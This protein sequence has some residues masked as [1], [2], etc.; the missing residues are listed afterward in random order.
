MKSCA[1][2]AKGEKK[3]NK[4]ILKGAA[5]LSI[6]AAASLAGAYALKK[7]DMAGKRKALD[8]GTSA[9]LIYVLFPPI[10]EGPKDKVKNVKRFF[11]YSFQRITKGYCDKDVWEMYPHL[12]AI[13]PAML[14]ELRENHMGYPVINEKDT[15]E[16]G[17]ERWNKILDRMAFCFRESCD[18]TCSRINPY[19]EEH[20]EALMKFTKKY[21]IFGEKLQ[22]K[23][24]RERDKRGEGKKMHFMDELPEYKDISKKYHDYEI[25]LAKYR[26]QK[27]NEAFNLLK[28]YFFGL[29]D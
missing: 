13:I 14:S 26:E 11:K 8:S 18:D 10:K 4:K 3:M 9:N 27:K 20:S 6:A 5:A 1:L 24:E 19:K 29:F 7:A 25:K 22:T 15:P 12:Q 21:G 2:C 16:E 23:E 17:D 28:K